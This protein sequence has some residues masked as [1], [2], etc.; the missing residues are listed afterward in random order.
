MKDNKILIAGLIG[1]IV[2]FLLGWLVYGMMLNG[3]FQSNHGSATG[4]DRN[5]EEMVWWAMIVGHL[6]IGYLIA[7]I[8]G[9]WANISNPATG[10]KAG[11]IL[12]ALMGLIGFI[13]Y[14]VSNVAN[15]TATCVNVIAT[16]IITAIVGAA[17]AWWLGRD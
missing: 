6:A 8:Y 5:P 4:V 2:A 9:R 7:I 17:V 10:A 1:G 16:A 3:F 13:N 14:G 12:G 15:V 11:A